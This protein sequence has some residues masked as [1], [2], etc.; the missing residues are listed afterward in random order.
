LQLRNTIPYEDIVPDFTTKKMFRYVIFVFAFAALFATAC[1]SRPDTTAKKPTTATVINS[2][3]DKILTDDFEAA[4]DILQGSEITSNEAISQ[5]KG[6]V[7]QYQAIQAA[8]KKDNKTTYKKHI[9][10]LDDILEKDIPQEPNQLGKAFAALIQ[11]RDHAEKSRKETL[12]QEPYVK[13]LTDTAILAA[14]K[15]RDEGNWVDAYAYGYY[16][17]ERLDEENK[18]YK[19]QSERLTEMAL[20]ELSLMDNSCETAADRHEGIRQDMFF[21]AIQTL[22]RNYVDIIDYNALAEKSIER[23]Y[24]LGE[25]LSGSKKDLAYHGE[26]AKMS[27]WTAGLTEIKSSTGRTAGQVTQ[28]GLLEIFEQILLLNARSLNLPEEVVISQIAEASLKALDPF[29]SLVWPWQ[30]KDFQKNMTQEFTGIGI[31]ISKTTGKLTVG[32]LLPDTP[33]YNTTS[34][35]AGDVIEAID[36]EKVTKEMS[37]N[38]AVSKITGPRGTKVVLTVRHEEAEETEEITIVRDRII[39]PTI[40]GWSRDA[41]GWWQYMLDE[42][43][44]L[45]YIRITNFTATTTPDMETILIGLERKGL[46]GLIIDLRF[47]TGGY[48]ETAAAIVD[49]FIKSGPIVKS[50]PR[51]SIATNQEKAHSTGTHPNYPVVVLINGGSA[52]ASE[53]VA[54]ALQD[55]RYKRATL[56]GSRTY[57]KGSVQ[58]ITPAAGNAQLKYTTAYY[59]LPSEQRVKNRYVME[60]QG[61]KDWGIKADVKIKLTGSEMQKM[62]DMRRDNE[63]LARAGTNNKADSKRHTAEQTIE[64]DPQIAVGLLVLKTKLIQSGKLLKSQTANNTGTDS[65]TNDKL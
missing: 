9:D 2:A 25:V 22:D 1:Q 56:V 65:K 62:A 35:D 18:D 63:T 44:G 20:I 60:K 14:N 45:G 59:H 46:K 7:E 42:S 5:L 28:A 39:V 53:I 36:G 15:F 30:I 47:N 16:W 57:G 55:K 52:S 12:L 4:G 3:C 61:R 49:M 24:L 31:E 27:Q 23:C 51:W 50:Q 48:L 11:A 34:L 13:K 64:S 19:S 29:T 8:R 38:C 26:T 40:K 10:E 21:Q 37:L 32:G 6:I 54:G 43:N 17:L 33:A 41:S 58:V